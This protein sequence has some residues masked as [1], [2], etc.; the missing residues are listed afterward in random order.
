MTW[1]GGLLFLAGAV[2]IPAWLLVTGRRIR[3]KGR[4]IRGAFWGGIA[5]HLVGDVLFLAALLAPPLVWP[6]GRPAWTVPLL[7]V[8]PPVVGAAVGAAIGRRKP[9]RYG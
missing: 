5:G 3:H 1:A 6:P 8:I 9:L 7:L 4:R 2:L